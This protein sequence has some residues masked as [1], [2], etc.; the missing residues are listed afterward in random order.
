MK[1]AYDLVDY[2]YVKGQAYL[3]VMVETLDSQTASYYSLPVGPRVASVN[4]GSCAEKAGIQVGDIIVQFNGVEVENNTGL[5]AALKKVQAGDAV[6]VTLFRAGAQVE[7]TVVLDERPP[8]SEVDAMTEQ[9][10]AQQE[11]EQ[12]QEE[13]GGYYYQYPYG[14]GFGG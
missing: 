7:V 12:Q 9:Y 4:A 11:Q 3:G 5:L 14:F 6:N 2:G 13:S 10:Q 8:E 1:V